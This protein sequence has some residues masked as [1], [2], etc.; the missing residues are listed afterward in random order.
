MYVNFCATLPWVETECR[1]A[2]ELTQHVAHVRP[3]IIDFALQGPMSV[4]KRAGPRGFHICYLIG[5]ANQRKQNER[6]VVLV[7]D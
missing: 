2:A 7:K 4:E 3:I 6:N 5:C 1:A